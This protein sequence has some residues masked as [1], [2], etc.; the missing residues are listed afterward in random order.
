[1]KTW[2]Y[3]LDGAP[4]PDV[5]SPL[6]VRQIG[7]WMAN[8]GSWWEGLRQ[9]LDQQAEQLP[10]ENH[11]AAARLLQLL[12]SGL[13][14]VTHDR[15]WSV[16]P[17]RLQFMTQQLSQL[18]NRWETLAII[19]RTYGLSPSHLT[20]WGKRLL[21]FWELSTALRFSLEASEVCEHYSLEGQHPYEKQLA[22]TKQLLA[23]FFP[24]GG[25]VD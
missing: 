14:V 20:V 23:P 25:L 11:D 5:P 13:P 17:H 2:H 15:L 9:Q 10:Q 21:L 4:P 12:P 3:T 19:R 1:M 18:A 8:L 24:P 7:A 6:T 22:E 16:S